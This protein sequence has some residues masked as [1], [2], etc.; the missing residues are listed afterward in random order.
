M[1]NNEKPKNSELKPAPRIQRYRRRISNWLEAKGF[2]RGLSPLEERY[3]NECIP[4]NQ[5]TPTLPLG[6]KWPHEQD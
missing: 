6:D 4:K 1:Q 2:L 5:Y 3:L